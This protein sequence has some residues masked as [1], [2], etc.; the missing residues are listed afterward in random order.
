MDGGAHSRHQL[1]VQALKQIDIEVVL[2]RFKK[3]DILC[4]NCETMF[5]AHEEKESDVNIAC[6]LI[7]DAHRD[8]FD[9]AFIVTRDSDLSGPLRFITELFPKK[10]V[11]V[12]AP[13][14]RQ[15]SKELWSLA[16]LRA[17]INET[18]LERC[19]LPAQFVDAEGRVTLL[20]PS[21]Y[22]PPAEAP[23]RN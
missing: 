4:K 7:S 5:T 8:L 2:G 17:S 20:R 14:K 9:Q 3:K 18:H 1:Y 10:R 22:D 19:L 12:I 11:K 13:P 15:H 16:A 6:H 23:D 21:E